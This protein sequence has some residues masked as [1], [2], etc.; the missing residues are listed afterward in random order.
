MIGKYIRIQKMVFLSNIQDIGR[1]FRMKPSPG[2][3]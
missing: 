2:K 1:Y 3:V